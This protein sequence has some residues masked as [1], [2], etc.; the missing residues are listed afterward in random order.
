MPK[1]TPGPW[2]VDL[3]DDTRVV[4]ATGAEVAAIDGDYNAPDTWPKMEANAR[5]IAAAPDLL[6]AARANRAWSYAESKN[7][8]SFEQR[9]ALCAHADSLTRIALAKASGAEPPAYKGL[10]SLTVWPAVELHETQQAEI[11]LLVEEA[12]RLM[13]ALAQAAE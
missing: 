12:F 11:N 6:A 13:D 2:K 8:G 1:H 4:D 3:V 9:C 10:P 5:L 7:L